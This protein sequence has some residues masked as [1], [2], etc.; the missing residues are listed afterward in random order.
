MSLP[1]VAPPAPPPPPPVAPPSLLSAPPVPTLLK[2]AVSNSSP[3]KPAIPPTIARK[4]SN[5]L[6]LPVAPP[7]APPARPTSN[8]PSLPSAPPPPLP[9]SV[10]P[11]PARINDPPP[12]RS[13]APPPPP[14]PQA[15]FRNSAQAFPVS[16]APV[17]A[18]PPP[19]APPTNGLSSTATHTVTHAPVIAPPPPA[20]SQTA[21]SSDLGGLQAALASR[22]QDQHNNSRSTSAS[23]SGDG[24]A[25][26]Y[27]HNE[28]PSTA[29]YSLKPQA[30]KRVE[31]SKY[32]FQ[33]D[34]TLPPIRQFTNCAKV[35]KSGRPGGSTVPLN[36]AAL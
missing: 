21:S 9:S 13:V 28:L 17:F 22:S 32:R 18:P 19:P 8:P 35:Y 2:T 16:Q 12:S 33:P 25:N 34:N 7:S 27:D 4:T 10:S 11:A 5:H 3:N 36:L 24:V 20:Q 1:A 6:S 31:D 23:H 26:G 14:P 29:N 15:N 30:I